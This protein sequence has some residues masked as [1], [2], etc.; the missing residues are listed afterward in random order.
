MQPAKDAAVEEFC[1]AA[2]QPREAVL[3]KML[4]LA[5]AVR[6]C[7]DDDWEH[8]DDAE[9]AEMMMSDGCFLLEFM[10]SM[11]P[12][13][14]PPA[15]DHGS[16]PPPPPPTEPDEFLSRPEVHR[17]I[18]A[19]ARDI[20]MLD[21]QIPWF[22]LEALMELRRPFAVPV[23][24]FLALM[25]SAFDIG[26]LVA[27]DDGPPLLAQ[28]G[29]EHD[30][31]RDQPPP[32][33]HLL[34]LFHRRQV[35]A[36]AARTESL[37]IP[38]LPSLSSTAVELA[39]MGVK[40][41]A[42]KSKKFGDMVMSKRRQPLGVFGELSLAPVVLSELTQCWLFHMAAYEAC[43][44]VT[45]PDNFAVSSYI[46]A[47]SLLVNRPED[48]H[49]L[50]AKGVVVSAFSDQS[51]LSFFKALAR[52]LHVGHRYYDV[53]QR[54]HEYRQERWIWIAVHKFWYKNFKTIVTVLSVVGVLVG[55]FKSILSLKQHQR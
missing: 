13:D 29:G 34:G 10:V 21:N 6:R 3:E 31:G 32:P 30:D 11:C 15:A 17:R 41:A 38:S 28:Q 39:E 49:E 47:V 14:G 7:Y 40:L 37:R 43:L 35:G 12:Y 19:I 52:E 26:N 8:V 23:D 53:F 48:V 44:G 50:R 51:T 25:A 55:L 36:A 46:N 1:R 54:L 33:P 2:S 24:R 20:F 5:E 18:V 45:Q 4:S 9:L 16:P 27:D 42:S 22:V